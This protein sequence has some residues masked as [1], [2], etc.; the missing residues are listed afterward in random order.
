MQ[1]SDR[2]AGASIAARIRRGGSDRGPPRRAARRRPPRSWRPAKYGSTS[3]SRPAGSR[4]SSFSVR[5]YLNALERLMVVENQPAWAPHLR[6]RSRLRSGPKRRFVDPSLAVACLRATP[7][8]ILDCAKPPT[9]FCMSFIDQARVPIRSCAA[10]EDDA[11][12]PICP[13]ITVCECV[14]DCSS[15]TVY[16][17]S[18]KA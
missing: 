5:D 16:W 9:C 15:R 1:T 7:D 17:A 6:S 13:W 4:G 12:S 2:R 3:T 18:L 14:R 11:S 10:C 8:R